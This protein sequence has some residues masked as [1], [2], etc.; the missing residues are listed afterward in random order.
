MAPADAILT[1]QKSVGA[2]TE[3][4]HHTVFPVPKVS[5]QNSVVEETSNRV[6][7][8]QTG[9]QFV[10]ASTEGWQVRT[11]ESG[12][13]EVQRSYSRRGKACL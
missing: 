10:G 13:G 8:A 9:K 6:P 11:E 12:P 3:G 7:P 4:T 5:D 1:G 2:S